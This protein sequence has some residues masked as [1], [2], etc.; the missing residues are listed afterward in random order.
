MSTLPSII[1]GSQC[2]NWWRVLLTGLFLLTC[3]VCFLRHPRT[4]CPGVGLPTMGW[5]CTHH[6]ES[7]KC[8]HTPT[9]LPAG[10]SWECC[11]QWAYPMSSWHK[12]INSISSTIYTEVCKQH[13]NVRNS[14][15]MFK[16]Q[17]KGVS[18]NQGEPKAHHVSKND[19]EFLILMLPPS[20]GIELCFTI[21]YSFHILNVFF[22]DTLFKK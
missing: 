9:D 15:C 22:S 16:L 20:K 19:S 21:S 11:S 7:S 14:V 8:T 1:K 13:F 18:W 6:H 2:R 10:Q 3:S 17:K 5:A 4:T 12:S